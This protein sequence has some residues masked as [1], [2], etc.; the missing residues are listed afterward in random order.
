MHAFFATVVGLWLSRQIQGI[1]PTFFALP[2]HP[3]KSIA[4]PTL[5]RCEGPSITIS[6]SADAESIFSCDTYKGD[7]IIDPSA[8]GPIVLDG[9]RIITGH[10]TAINAINF[11]NVSSTSLETVQGSIHVSGDVLHGVG[12]LNLY[13]PKLESAG[14]I[15][16]SDVM[17]VM[18]PSLTTVA[19]AMGIYSSSIDSFTFPS[20]SSSGDF[21]ELVDCGFYTNIE[22]P[23]TL[24]M[25]ALTAVGGD[26][27]VLKGVYYSL[28]FPQLEVVSG[29]IQFLGNLFNLTMP[30]LTKV[31]SNARIQ[32]ASNSH[33]TIC[34]EMHRLVKESIIEGH[35]KCSVTPEYDRSSGV[36]SGQIVGV[37]IGTVATAALALAAF[38]RFYLR[39]KRHP[40]PA[41]KANPHV[42]YTGPEESELP[43]YSQHDELKR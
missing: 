7:V 24:T 6:S 36:S 9:P 23:F 8:Q 31:G 1:V 15:T 32:T 42:R 21:I 40:K 4:L 19:G 34:D 41:A 30:S 5:P 13:L 10:L 2:L 18:T 17:N 43:P 35:G 29:S 33:D 26:L 16:I 12:P 22:T 28:D 3:N 14:N 20:L 37:V 27:I 11:D 39:P 38:Y 25:G